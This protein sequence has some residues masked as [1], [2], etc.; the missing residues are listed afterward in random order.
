MDAKNAAE[1]A[2][3]GTPKRKV[4]KV[5]QQK[6]GASSTT[7]HQAGPARPREVHRPTEV[8]AEPC[9]RSFMHFF[10]FDAQTGRVTYLDDEKS[11]LGEV[12][13]CHKCGTALQYETDRCPVCGARFDEGDTGIVGLLADRGLDWEACAELDCPQCGEHVTLVGGKC[14]ACGTVLLSDDTGQE[15]APRSSLVSAENV[16]F[17]HLDVESGEMEYLQRLHKNRGFEHMAVRLDGAGS[18]E[19]QGG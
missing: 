18:D 13:E 8:P 10:H 1:E 16:I 2:T 14:P 9:K 7:E 11:S 15:D 17:V 3:G 19:P 12:C 6:Q 4:R 5:R